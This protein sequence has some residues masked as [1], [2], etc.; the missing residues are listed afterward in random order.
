M[1]DTWKNNG[2]LLTRPV[3]A[4]ADLEALRKVATDTFHLDIDTRNM[5]REALLDAMD[6]Q[7]T[8]QD[9]LPV[10]GVSWQDADAYC[11]WNGQR[12][13]T[14]QEWEKAARG[15]DGRV[16]PWGNTWDVNKA[17]MGGG[18]GRESGLAPVGSYPQ[19]DSVY[20]VQDMAGNVMEWTA[21]WYGPYPGS[22]YQSKDFGRKFKVVRGGSWGGMGHYAISYFYRTTYRF[23]LAPA[24]RFPDLGFRCV[25]DSDD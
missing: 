14:E 22:D 3:L 5:T 12:L 19:G 10:G 20:G 11:R 25:G 8:V 6:K 7:R 13:P 18:H 4:A 17:N 16:Y 23:F 24:S 1:P 15:T 9:S 21:D 2:Y